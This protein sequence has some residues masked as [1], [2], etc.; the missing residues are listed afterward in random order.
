MTD[1]TETDDA[2]QTEEPTVEQRALNMG[3]TAKEDFKGDPDKWVD[4]ETFVK[5][6]EEF[7]PF[8]RA[9][10]K[11]LEAALDAARDEIK[12]LKKSFKEFGEF[13]TKT[14][15]RAYERA[16]KDLEDQQAAAVQAG[17]VAGVKKATEDIVALNKEVRQEAPKGSTGDPS[18]QEAFDDWAPEN[19]WFDKDK[20]LT[21]FAIAE[22][23]DLPESMSPAARLKA[24]AKKVREEFPQKFQNERRKA[25]PA[26][27]GGG[28]ARASSGKTWSDLPAEAKATAE[29]WARQGLITKEQYVKDYFA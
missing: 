18:F 13:H 20:A 3:W 8:L 12:G 19:A 29:R 11:K 9:N 14:E 27:E 7:I 28:T 22:Y 6:G 15:Q 16:L 25:P 2:P 24:I 1:A 10:N 26:V 23:E 4:A 21:A 17:D 5:R